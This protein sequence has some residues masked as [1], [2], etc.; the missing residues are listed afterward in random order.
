MPKAGRGPGFRRFFRRGP[1]EAVVFTG[2]R[3][4]AELVLNLLREEGFHPLLWADLPTPSYAGP[5]GMAR[6]VVPPDE[7][8]RAEAFLAGLR[9]G[10]SSDVDG[11]DDAGATEPDGGAGPRLWR[12]SRF[13]GITT[14]LP[15]F[16][17]LPHPVAWR[18]DA[19]LRP[20]DGGRGQAGLAS[21][22][23]RRKVSS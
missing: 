20:G 21:S 13:P 6:V 8:D 7:A 2:E 5:I 17:K 3:T 15:C 23:S 10:R 11:S 19:A 12:E 22:R 4:E 16:Q 18:D 14:R 1:R 9:E